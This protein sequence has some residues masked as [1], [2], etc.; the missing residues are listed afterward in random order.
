MSSSEELDVLDEP[1]KRTSRTATRDTYWTLALKPL[2]DY[3][4]K[5]IRVRTYA[6]PG[7]AN[8]VAHRLRHDE[9]KGAPPGKWDAVGRNGELWVSYIQPKGEEI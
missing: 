3:P 2:M 1:P 5:W 7:A 6:T 9:V 8:Q 4:G